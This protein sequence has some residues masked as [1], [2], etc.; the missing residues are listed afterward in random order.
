[1]D[2]YQ[3]FAIYQRVEIGKGESTIR[4]Y[5]GDVRRFREWLDTRAVERGLPPAWEEVGARHIR[6]YTA[7]LS[8]DR[9]VTRKD[10]ALIEQRAVGAK[11]VRRIT[12]SLQVWFDYLRDIGK[13]RPDNPAR[14]VRAPKLPK[15]HPPYLAPNEVGKLVR[16][17]VEHSRTPERLRNWTMIAFL[18]NTGLR[19]SELCNMKLSDIRYRDRLPHSVRVIGK[20]NKEDVIVLNTE[21]KRALYQWLEERAHVEAS[22]PV[23]ADTSYVWLIPA[24][25]KRGHPITP[26]GVRAVM[27][28]MGPLAGLSKRT[29]PHVMRHSFANAL[30]RG[31]AKAHAVQ[32]SMRHSTLSTTGQYFFA[33]ESD[34]EQAVAL[35]PSVLAPFEPGE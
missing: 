18:Y 32:K 28:R 19:V 7:W 30:I 3:Q 27:R 17:A 14:E 4:A 31:G 13:L 20:G 5:L 21:A 2:Y 1:M 33:D 6:A 16:S 12:A 25:R 35:V 29:N 34:L 15:R 10:G 24:G 23:E 8:T 9:K 22:A 11:Y 26:P